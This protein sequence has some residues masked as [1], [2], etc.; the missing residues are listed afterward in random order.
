M[1]LSASG[2]GTFSQVV[3]IEHDLAAAAWIDSLFPRSV[4]Y[5]GLG[6]LDCVSDSDVMVG[7]EC[8]AA[9]RRRRL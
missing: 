4:L 8:S 2:N 5:S 9:L 1:V 6:K 3:S 7:G